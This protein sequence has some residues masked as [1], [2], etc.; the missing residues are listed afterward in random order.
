M[1]EYWEKCK[2]CEKDLKELPR[3]EITSRGIGYDSDF[4][5]K[6]WNTDHIVSLCSRECMLAYAI[7]LILQNRAEAEK[8]VLEVGNGNLGIKII[9][10]EPDAERRTD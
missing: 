5:F 2:M 1:T 10:K 6:T 3:I 8:I 9:E 7:N 4:N